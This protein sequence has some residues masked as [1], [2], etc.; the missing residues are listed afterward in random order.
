MFGGIYDD[1]LLIKPT[2]K[3]K[4]LGE[5][6]NVSVDDGI[7]DAKGKIDLTKSK[8]ICYDTDGHGY[9]TL[10]EKSAKLFLTA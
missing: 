9:Y 2:E 10:G 1:R 8:P 3:A 6:V 7:L 4:T 5:V